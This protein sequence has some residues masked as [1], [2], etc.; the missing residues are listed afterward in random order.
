[1]SNTSSS[2][3]GFPAMLTI[4]FVVLKLTG[5]IEWSWVWVLC[6]L[7]ISL[8]IGLLIL[9]GAVIAALVIR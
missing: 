5:V 3:P 1:M 4:T 9:A 7:W 6:P 8:I 2:G